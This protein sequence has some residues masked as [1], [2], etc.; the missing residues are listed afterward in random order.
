MTDADKNI[1]SAALEYTKDWCGEHQ[2]EVGVAEMALGSAA[3]A[4]GIQ[5]GV[6]EMGHDLV[7]RATSNFNIGEMAGGAIGGVAGA[8]GGAILGGIGVAALGT[9]VGIPTIAIVGGGTLLFGSFGYTVGDLT[10]K[11][12]NPP[13][14]LGEFLGGASVMAI[15]LALLIDGAR[16]VVKDQRVIAMGTKL[17]DGIIYLG[18]QS[19]QIVAK[20]TKEF[21]R[22]ADKM[23]PDSL[24]I[25]GPVVTT[26]AATATATVATGAAVGS[27]LAAGS[28]TVL[29]SQTVGA[30]A[31]SLGLVSAPVWP[32]IAGGA[33][34]LAVGYG[35]FR[36]VRHF[37]ARR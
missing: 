37:T 7:V 27:S 4:W 2:W 24:G 23:I 8:I 32:G 3:I 25:P 36:T 21:Y 22:L 16:R 33:A 15:G 12:L 13:V 26:T 5:N 14:D 9:A 35:A 1:F 20:T 29:G 17:V 34:G 19:A 6:I 28:V 31:L 18:N 10:G 30:A 11:F